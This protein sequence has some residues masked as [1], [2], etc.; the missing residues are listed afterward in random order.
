MSSSYP[1]EVAEG[2]FALGRWWGTLAYLAVG[3]ETLLVDTGVSRLAG[4]ILR[5]I[6]ATGIDPVSVDRIVLTHYD[7]DHSG[8][9]AQ[10]A[11]A[12]DA[13]VVIHAADAALL[14]NPAASPGVRRLIYHQPVPRVLQWEPPEIAAT[15]QEGDRLGDWQVLHTPGH[16]P[17]SLSLVRD[18]VGIVGDALLY[19]RGR[20]IPNV[21]HLAID[22]EAQDASAKRLATAG[23]RTVLPGHYSACTDPG[24]VAKLRRRL[25][26]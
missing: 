24:A 6:R 23:L 22:L 19:S 13:P 3:V 9:A 5:A 8:S 11:R 21:R 25:G 2:V 16:T 15:L 12:L 26:A 20:L 1:R 18:D 10:L 7:Y 4:T 17:G 14:A